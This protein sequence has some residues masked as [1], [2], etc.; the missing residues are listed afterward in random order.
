MV[1][2]MAERVFEY[3]GHWLA[4]R[5]PGTVWY[6]HWYMPDGRRT[7]RRSTNSSALCVAK[8]LLVAKVHGRRILESLEATALCP[9]RL[10]EKH[11]D[12]DLQDRPGA[13]HA[14]AALKQFRVFFDRQLISTVR[15]LTY[16]AQEAFVSWR[17]EGLIRAGHSGSNGTINRDLSVLRAA[18]RAAWKRGHLTRPPFVLSLPA[19]LPRQR[20]L[21]IEEFRRLLDVCTLPHLYLFIMMMVHTMQRP[22]AILSLR[23]DAVD[24]ELNRIDF[25]RGQAGRTNKR[26][27][28]VPITE[29]LRP[30]L[31]AAMGSSRSGH[32]IE[33]RGR[34]I[35]SVTRS[36]RSAVRRAGLGSEATPYT[37]RH[38]AATHAA[39]SGVP[40]REI[41]GMMGHTTSSMTERHYAKF[42]AGYLRT[43]ATVLS[44][45]FTSPERRVAASPQ[46]QV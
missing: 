46:D 4:V 1:V 45:H 41:A 37:L 44:T 33:L 19:P 5:S 22:A 27:S 14:R 28:V 9:I 38:T 15:D 30:L 36:F 26:R 35:R 25:T 11:I 29:T 43:V 12:R 39:A 16:E 8:R 40:M 34:P 20:Y 23:V 13:A 6:I 24:L 10:M 2:G 17:R 3:E 42:H 7:R 18:L 31:I 21:S 32:V